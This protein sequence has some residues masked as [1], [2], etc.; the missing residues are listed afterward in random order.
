MESPE[1]KELHQK[2]VERLKDLI[3]QANRTCALLESMTEF[4]ITLD[5]WLRAVDQRARENEAQARY[6]EVRERL[7]H[8]VRPKQKS[9]Q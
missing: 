8:A 6:Q 3:A 7:F 2:C 4:P 5:V 9:E 1:I